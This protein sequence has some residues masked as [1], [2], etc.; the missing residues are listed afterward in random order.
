MIHDG[1]SELFKKKKNRNTS[2]DDQKNI[3]ECWQ[4][5][6]ITRKLK[7]K[8]KKEMRS[9]VQD[10]VR[11]KLYNWKVAHVFATLTA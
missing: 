3:V 6:S 2:E 9:I 4:H 1:I 7:K 11:S 5:V 10:S 8:R